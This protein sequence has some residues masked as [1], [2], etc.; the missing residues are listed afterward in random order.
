MIKVYLIKLSKPIEILEG[1]E[2]QHS[3]QQQ[4][5]HHGSPDTADYFPEV[6]LFWSVT[7]R[8]SFAEI[9]LL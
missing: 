7:L 6:V 4:V 8:S 1:R 9:G 2:E 3:P 5:G